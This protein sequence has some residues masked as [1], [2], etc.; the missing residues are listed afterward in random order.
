MISLQVV[1][2]NKSSE[3]NVPP[4]VES[5]NAISTSYLL[6]RALITSDAILS[7]TSTTPLVISS[8]PK[9]TQ[10]SGAAS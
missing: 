1:N 4:A 7:S 3:I 8:A 5:I 2:P 10:S 6:H 9:I